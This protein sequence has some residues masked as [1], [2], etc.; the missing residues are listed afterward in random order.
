M[1]GIGHEVNGKE[2]KKVL[3]RGYKRNEGMGEMREMGEEGKDEGDECRVR[4]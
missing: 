2:Y 3:I 4:I 1:M